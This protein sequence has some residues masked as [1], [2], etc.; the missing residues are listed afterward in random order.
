MF[1]QNYQDLLRTAFPEA[2][3][4]TLENP[5]AFMI[6]NNDLKQPAR[7][8]HEEWGFRCVHDCFK[9]AV[10]RSNTLQL[11]K[12][13]EAE[14]CLDHWKMIVSCRTFYLGG[15]H[16]HIEIRNTGTSPLPFTET[17]YQSAFV[18]LAAFQDGGTPEDFVRAQFPKVTQLALF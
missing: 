2:V 1:F 18:P 9:E 12:W 14:V 3:H 4:R 17:G 8:H 5:Q 13:S 11:E 16:A 10:P 7:H 15:N 6:I